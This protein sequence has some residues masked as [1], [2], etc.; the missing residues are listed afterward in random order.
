[1]SKKHYKNVVQAV[2]V[3][4]WAVRVRDVKVEWVVSVGCALNKDKKEKVMRTNGLVREP[5]S[6]ACL[7]RRLNSTG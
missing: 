5:A 2:R 4:E 7:A 1:M 6:L 3:G